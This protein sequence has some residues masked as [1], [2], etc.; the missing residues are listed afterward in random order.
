MLCSVLSPACILH[1]GTHERAPVEA[2]FL[3]MLFPVMVKQGTYFYTDIAAV[4]L[5]LG[6][7][8]IQNGKYQVVSETSE[9]SLASGLAYKVHVQHVR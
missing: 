9:A 2:L 8:G 1:G 3:L 7:S 5:A 4:S 6:R